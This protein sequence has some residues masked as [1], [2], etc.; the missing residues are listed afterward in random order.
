MNSPASTMGRRRIR[1]AKSTS[2]DPHGPISSTSR[3]RIAG[4]RCWTTA[5]LR[6]RIAGTRMAACSGGSVRVI[7]W[8]PA[9]SPTPTDARMVPSW[10]LNVR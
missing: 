2:P 3:S 5:W 9:V 6:V 1:W 10:E 7:V 4:V 8:P